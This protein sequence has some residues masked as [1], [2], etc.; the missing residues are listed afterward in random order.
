MSTSARARHQLGGRANGQRT[1][2]NTAKIE[3]SESLEYSG[4]STVQLSDGQSDCEVSFFSMIQ[5][6]LLPSAWLPNRFRDSADVDAVASAA[7][8]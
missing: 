1:S 2:S 7:A 5:P 8:C 3:I 6:L 4:S